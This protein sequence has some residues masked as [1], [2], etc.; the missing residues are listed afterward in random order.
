MD[1]FIWAISF[2]LVLLIFIGFH[3]VT[4]L[5]LSI[6]TITKRISL[7]TGIYIHRY[8]T[9]NL[10]EQCKMKNA[11]I[12]A[13][14]NTIDASTLRKWTSVAVAPSSGVTNRWCT[15]QNVQLLVNYV[16]SVL[17][18]FFIF[19]VLRNNKTSGPKKF[20]CCILNDM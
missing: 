14:L 16:G 6:F 11:A 17:I 2:S 19:L 8:V 1:F 5:T 20:C 18:L 7:S 10:L 9:I 3:M 4:L 15:G 12:D 13:S